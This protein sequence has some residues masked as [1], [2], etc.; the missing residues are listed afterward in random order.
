MPRDKQT[1]MS[2]HIKQ[3]KSSVK[4]SGVEYKSEHTNNIIACKAVQEPL[5][6]SCKP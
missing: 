4:Q 6:F 1:T 2:L 5:S 3:S